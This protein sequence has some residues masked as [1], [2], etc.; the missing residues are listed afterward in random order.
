M[1]AAIANTAASILSGM[2]V[3]STAVSSL[4]PST[5]MKPVPPPLI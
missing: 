5:V 4:T 3:C 2:T 1:A